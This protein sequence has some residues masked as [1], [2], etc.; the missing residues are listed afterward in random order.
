MRVSLLLTR[1]G[2]AALAL[3]VALVAFGAPR[4]GRAAADPQP[5][6]P[7]YQSLTPIRLLGV[8]R[9]VYRE[10]RP[11]PLYETYTLVRKENTDYGYPDPTSSY[12]KHYWV[13]NSDRAALMRYVYR[14][15]Y[16]GDMTFD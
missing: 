14:D 9:R 13:R 12:V 10:H 11:P 4:A 16:D 3:C 2:F 6:L 1:V 8:I 7:P 15:D 5:T